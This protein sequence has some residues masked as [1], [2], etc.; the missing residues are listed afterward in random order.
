[1]IL[2]LVPDYVRGFTAYTPSRPDPELMR[3]YGVNRLVRCNNNENPLGPP[4][5]ARKI[6]EGFDWSRAALYPNGDG[7]YLRNA[8]AEKFGKHPEQ[9]LVGNGSCEIIGSVIKAFCGAGDNIVTADK[10]FAV[11]EWVGVFLGLEVRLVPLRNFGFDA[12]AMLAAIDERTKVVFVCN[13]NNPTGAWWDR[14]TM[15]SFLE[16][17]AGRCIVVAD[18]AYIEYVEQPGFPDAMELLDAWPNLLTFRTFSKMYGLAGLRAGYLCGSRE[19]VDVVRRTHVAYSVNVLA[20]EA[21]RAALADD[22][23]HILATRAAAA[24]ARKI[25]IEAFMA[26]G[27]E[28]VAGEGCFVMVRTP[29]SDTLLYRQLMRRGFMVRTMT[30]FRFPNWVRVSL[31]L[32]EDM[33]GLC[34]AL[35]DIL[36]EL[37]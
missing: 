28:Y 25:L 30:G 24:G 17:V 27:L 20:Q 18:E 14:E 6:L 19:A 2:R 15:T 3:L 22:R 7:F 12:E 33:L 8:L 9:F 10:T 35:K 32:Q 16:G 26:M 5:A 31:G 4:P 11:Y 1:M 36:A 23:E 34:D 13:P 21:A 37:R 29:M